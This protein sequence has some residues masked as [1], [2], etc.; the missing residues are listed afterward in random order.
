MPRTIYHFEQDIQGD[1]SHSYYTSLE[2][3]I[4]DNMED[5]NISRST[6]QKWNAEKGKELKHE[7]W[8]IRKGVAFSAAEIRK[9]YQ[10]IEDAAPELLGEIEGHE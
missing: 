7:N 9:Y 10:A 5:L 6:L 8:I 1:I 4:I 3:L 2:G